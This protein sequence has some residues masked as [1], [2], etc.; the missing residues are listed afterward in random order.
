MSEPASFRFEQFEDYLTFERGL[1]DRTV[2]AYL[3]DLRRWVEAMVGG[4]AS[5][6][7]DVTAALLRAWI[8]GL[9]DLAFRNR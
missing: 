6:P 2:A 3:R 4:G 9:K 7:G 8:F 1:S 5:G